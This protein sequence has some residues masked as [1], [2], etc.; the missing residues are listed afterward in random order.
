LHVYFLF[1]VLQA[2]ARFLLLAQDRM[3]LNQLQGLRN[4][5][6]KCLACVAGGRSF[7]AVGTDGT[8]LNLL[9]GLGHS[10]VQQYAALTPLKGAHP[11][12]Q[13][14]AGTCF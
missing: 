2:G 10:L 3:G 7:P 13:Q 4:A 8:G 14:L 9:Q 11:G 5:I 1:A 12:G 6:S